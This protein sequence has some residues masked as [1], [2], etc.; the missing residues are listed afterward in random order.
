[1]L[2]DIAGAFYKLGVRSAARDAYSL[3]AVTAQEQYIRWISEINLME[4]AADDG[5]LPL[6]DR[7]RRR[8]DAA[9]LPPMLHAQFLVHSGEGLARLGDAGGA[10]RHFVAAI[11]FARKFNYHPIVFNAEAQLVQLA[12][13]TSVRVAEVPLPASLVSIA[14]D[15][16]QRQAALTHSF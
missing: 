9:A 8:L 1:M 7:H 3:L 5:S 16:R 14:S 2:G 10:R 6:F 12:E 15:L 4:I 13:I 11:A